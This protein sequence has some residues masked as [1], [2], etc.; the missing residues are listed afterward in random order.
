MDSF[1]CNIRHMNA[2]DDSYYA[3]LR[4]LLLLMMI[5]TTAAARLWS[6]VMIRSGTRLS[7]TFDTI[8]TQINVTLMLLLYVF[9]SDTIIAVTIDCFECNILSAIVDIE[10]EGGYLQIITHPFILH[11]VPQQSLNR[12]LSSAH[13]SRLVKDS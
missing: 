1:I 4:V 10:T 12:I 2:W 11:S 6:R 3:F 13:Q 8:Y 9:D 5:A 7:L